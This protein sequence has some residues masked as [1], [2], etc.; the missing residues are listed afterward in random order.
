MTV[1][2]G[3]DGWSPE[4]RRVLAGSRRGTGAEGCGASGWDWLEPILCHFVPIFPILSHVF[5]PVR[6]V[7]KLI[8]RRRR[9]IGGRFFNCGPF[10]LIVSYFLF[11]GV[12][13]VGNEVT[14]GD[15]GLCR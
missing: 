7:S 1:G 10:R 11:S 13:E 5:V 8:S 9:Q 14:V 15:V 2:G 4:W 12:A 3:K 6:V